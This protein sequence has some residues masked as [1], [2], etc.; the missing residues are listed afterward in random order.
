LAFAKLATNWVA[1]VVSGSKTAVA[2]R[3]EMFV[4]AFAT[5]GSDLN[6]FTTAFDHDAPQTMPVTANVA[7]FMP[8]GTTAVALS[9][10]GWQPVVSSSK[11]AASQLACSFTRFIDSPVRL[12]LS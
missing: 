4:D 8:S 10:L 6:C 7:D 9:P 12:M 11:I 5:P 2:V 3:C 1:L